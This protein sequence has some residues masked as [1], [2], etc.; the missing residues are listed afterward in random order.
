MGLFLPFEIFLVILQPIYK[1]IKDK[2]TTDICYAVLA[3]Q[4]RMCI[5]PSKT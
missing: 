5:M 1:S 3:R 4:K 2:W